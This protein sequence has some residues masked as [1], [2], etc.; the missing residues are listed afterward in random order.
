MVMGDYV[1]LERSET[2]TSGAGQIVVG[3]VFEIMGGGGAQSIS[4]KKRRMMFTSHTWDTGMLRN[5]GLTA[6]LKLTIVEDSMERM[7][8]C[9]E[10]SRRMHRLGGTMQTDTGRKRHVSAAVD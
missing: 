6:N 1:L 9:R 10:K 3:D 5:C 8:V 4:R 2:Y 7:P